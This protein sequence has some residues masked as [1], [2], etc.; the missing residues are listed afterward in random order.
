MLPPPAKLRR[1]CPDSARWL[2]LIV[3]ICVSS[4]RLCLF[5]PDI[6]RWWCYR[7]G[8]H[9][10]GLKIAIM[11]Q[12]LKCL[13]LSLSPSDSK[14]C[15]V[16][17]RI[18]LSCPTYDP[19]RAVC[20]SPPW[21]RFLVIISCMVESHIALSNRTNLTVRATQGGGHDLYYCCFVRMKHA[22]PLCQDSSKSSAT[23]VEMAKKT[24]MHI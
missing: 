3:H 24:N 20:Q 10:E 23:T 6:F 4:S 7:I 2:A 14:V 11:L 16:C 17:G 5:I 18:S 1:R 19:P 9:G 21:N 8:R 13:P 22:S 12:H 15:L